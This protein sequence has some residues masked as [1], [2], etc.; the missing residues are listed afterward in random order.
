MA[1][2]PH[3]RTVAICPAFDANAAFRIRQCR[4]GCRLKLLP[5]AQVLSSDWAFDGT[6]AANGAASGW[7]WFKAKGELSSGAVEGMNNKVKLLSRKSYGFRT[8]RITQP[9][10]LKYLVDLPES[11]YFNRFC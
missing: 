10:L 5:R 1:W 2:Y 6:E 8:V 4:G 7:N 11:E 3:C 9:T